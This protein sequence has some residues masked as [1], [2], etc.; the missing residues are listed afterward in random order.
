MAKLSIDVTKLIEGIK[1]LI[2]KK[3]TSYDA[4]GTVLRVEG[5]IAWVHI[6]GG[7]DETPVKMTIACKPGDVVPVR[8]SGGTA[9][10][11]GNKTAPP[12]DDQKAIVA[13]TVATQAETVAEEA[14]TT[15]EEALET[16]QDQQEHFWSDENGAHV[17]GMT[18][19]L[20]A[21]IKST[22]MHIVDTQTQEDVAYF[23]RNGAQIGKDEDSHISI[24][25]EG[26][27]LILSDGSEVI[28]AGTNGF[29]ML[30][31]R[32]Q[33][34]EKDLTAG[35]ES[36]RLRFKNPRYGFTIYFTATHDGVEEEYTFRFSSMAASTKTDGIVQ[37]SF[38]GTDTFTI[39]LTETADEFYIDGYLSYYS[40]S[41]T[42]YYTFGYRDPYYAIGNDSFA[43]GLY[44]AAPGNF[45]HAE[46]QGCVAAGL[47]SHAEGDGTEAKGDSSHTNGTGTIANYDDQTS[48]GRFNNNKPQNL[49][50]IGN[51][52]NENARSNAFEV[53]SSGH[54]TAE[55][56]DSHIGSIVTGDDTNSSLS[57]STAEELC[58]VTLTPGTW[59]LTGEISF[60]GA[61]GS[62]QR[63]SAAI[64]TTSGGMGG[65]TADTDFWRQ[66][67]ETSQNEPH[68]LNVMGAISVT[69]NI[70]YYLNGYS[71]VATTATYAYIKATRI[72]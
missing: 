63:L 2:E 65:A 48:I 33:Y 4:T 42:T 1:S 70:T 57:A 31:A 53:D 6:D 12:T 8:V 24:S 54:V 15:A 16:V 68:F 25:Q 35:S 62:G 19:G 18:N 17:K 26:M 58:S 49:F 52:S 37:V 5:D 39:S 55:G 67:L 44:V 27:T 13:H 29:F 14:N 23:T 43:S 66:D 72:A 7:V 60:A 11:V 51:G 38:D 30:I 47:C 69:G 41:Q 32:T 22:G 71:T 46:G 3:D 45:S 10:L 36:I 21:D 9:F 64:S 20:Q 61:T 34:F 59:I 56:H 28:G 50:E 40:F